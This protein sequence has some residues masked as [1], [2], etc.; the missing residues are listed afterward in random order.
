MVLRR[1]DGL[2][3][4]VKMMKLRLMIEKEDDE[5]NDQRKEEPF[6]KKAGDSPPEQERFAEIKIT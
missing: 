4:E 3:N 5:K 1:M 6:C 2:A